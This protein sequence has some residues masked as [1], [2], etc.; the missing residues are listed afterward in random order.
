LGRGLD[1][2]THRGPF[3]PLPFCDSDEVPIPERQVLSSLV[4][5]LC[6]RSSLV[7]LPVAPSALAGALGLVPC[8]LAGRK[9]L[10]RESEA[11]EVRFLGRGNAAGFFLRL[12]VPERIAAP[13][14][15]VRLDLCADWCRFR[16]LAELWSL[17]LFVTFAGSKN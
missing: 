2:V 13:V 10:C 12:H 3:Q 1:W 14:V 16:D 9:T 5:L 8:P 17:L 7:T 4:G 15:W 6:W 11:T